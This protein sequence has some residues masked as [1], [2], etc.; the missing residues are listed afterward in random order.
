MVNQQVVSLLQCPTCQAGTLS[1][2]DPG[3]L[4]GRM[5]TGELVC[6]RCARS[7]PVRHGV[8][9]LLPHDSLA[10]EDWKLWREHLAKFQARREDR[11][12][13]PNR[14]VSRWAKKSRPQQSFAGFIGITEGTLLDVG[15]GPGKFRLNFDEQQ[16]LY[17]GLDPIA[18]PDV[19]DFPFIRGLAEYVPFQDDTFTDVVVL[20]ALDHFRDR[21]GF[22]SEARR[23][24]IPTGKLHVL[25]SVHEIRGPVSA[26]KVI[27]HKV[28]DAV[29]DRVTRDRNLHAPKHLAEF[30][31]ASLLA[32]AGK[33]F[34]IVA[35]E[36]YSPL[37]YSP[38]KMFL[39]M[40]PKLSH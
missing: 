4:D 7:Y 40:T 18:L 11:I 21:E 27:G 3:L 22:F 2:S 10:T 24:L 26:I 19:S 33:Y 1:S 16:L 39:S 9:A 8:P 23:V 31:T 28:K 20:A 14:K 5:D 25:Q 37:W 36:K 17:V 38:V 15:C 35:I 32:L 6:A 30:G 34:D 12:Y 13:N 29:E